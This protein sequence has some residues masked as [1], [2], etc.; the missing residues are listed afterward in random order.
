M[1]TPYLYAAVAICCAATITA[2]D[3]TKSPP[4]DAASAAPPANQQQ[5]T[6]LGPWSTLGLRPNPDLHIIR[7]YVMKPGNE[8]H[9]PDPL[10]E[11][12]MM[13]PLDSLTV[14]QRKDLEKHIKGHKGTLALSI[15]KDEMVTMAAKNQMGVALVKAAL[16]CADLSPPSSPTTCTPASDTVPQTGLRPNPDLHIIRDYEMKPDNKGKEPVS[17][18]EVSMVIPLGGLTA[19]QRTDLETNIKNHEGGLVLAILK[20]DMTTMAKENPM[21]VALVKAAL[22]CTDLTRPISTTTC[23][24]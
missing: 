18:L 10:L 11:V 17:L 5:A 19:K 21:G 14:D 13:I 22:G 23:T 7:D 9:E 20:D 3:N 12:S 2:C 15:L 16:G 24:Q 4:S 8:G 1:A 6:A